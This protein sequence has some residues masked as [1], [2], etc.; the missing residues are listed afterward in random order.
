MS[1]A[2]EELTASY[3]LRAWH[4]AS[5]SSEGDHGTEGERESSPKAL[6][7]EKSSRGFALVGPD[8]L[9]ASYPHVSK[10]MHDVG[11]VQADCE[12]P[13][14]RLVYY[15]EISVKNAGAMGR[16]S[17]G[18]TAATSINSRHHPGYAYYFTLY[19]GTYMRGIVHTVF[20]MLECFPKIWDLFFDGDVLSFCFSCWTLNEQFITSTLCCL[21]CFG[22]MGI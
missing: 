14:Q 6:D 20:R 7:T 10:H 22:S 19:E 16:V 11:I 1:E 18:F 3:F 21:H 4:D 5:R 2:M 12:A 8:R 17:V 13:Q 15:F 9:S